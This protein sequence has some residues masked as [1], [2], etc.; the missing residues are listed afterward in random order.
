MAI[1]RLRLYV[2]LRS[3]NLMPALSLLG[4]VDREHAYFFVG[5]EVV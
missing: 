1:A 3:H 2:G 4:M 5:L